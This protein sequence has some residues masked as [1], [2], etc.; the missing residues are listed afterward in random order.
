M[1]YQLEVEYI[2]QLVGAV[3]GLLHIF[4]QG[5]ALQ[6]YFLVGD[7]VFQVV[8]IELREQGVQP[9]A[10]FL[11]AAGD[12][13]RIVRGDHYGGK[14][15]DMAAEFLV[16]IVVEGDFLFAFLE[17]ANHLFRAAVAV[18]QAFQPEPVG[19]VLGILAFAGRKVTPGEAEVV[20]GVE[21]VGLPGAV[22]AGNAYD[23]LVEPEVAPRVVFKLYD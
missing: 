9:F 7:Q 1:L 17:G 12:N 18:Q 10:A 14:L 13:L 6:Q 19:L 4:E 21:E 15:A 20:D 23:P 3:A 11:A 2:Q 16:L 5:V 22:A 8:G